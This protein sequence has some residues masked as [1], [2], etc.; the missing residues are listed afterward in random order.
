MNTIINEDMTLDEKLKAI[1]EALLTAASNNARRASVGLPPIDPAD[2][3]ICDGCEQM[4]R[5]ENE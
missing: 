5:K 4:E 2:L 3:T 1:D